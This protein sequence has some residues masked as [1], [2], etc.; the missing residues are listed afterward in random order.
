MRQR[1]YEQ[2]GRVQDLLAVRRAR[3][4]PSESALR[5]ADAAAG[6]DQDSTDRETVASVSWRPPDGSSARAALEA[7]VQRLR[8]QAV[9][10]PVAAEHR[11]HA[12]Q[13]HEA[14]DALRAS[15]VRDDGRATE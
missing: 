8:Q 5:R 14:A 13:A 15:A 6:R 12:E 10:A 4:D 1:P 2:T 11:R 7:R 3:P 9:T